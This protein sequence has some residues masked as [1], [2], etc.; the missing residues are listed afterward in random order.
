MPEH[1]PRFGVP[2][3]AAH[4]ITTGASAFDR[5]LTLR[6]LADP[7][8]RAEDFSRPGHMPP[9]AAVEGGLDQRRGLSCQSAVFISHRRRIA[10]KFGI[11]DSKVALDAPW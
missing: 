11:P 1:Y 3:D 6:L 7:T 9:L 10:G 8:S 4:G 5:A 2:V